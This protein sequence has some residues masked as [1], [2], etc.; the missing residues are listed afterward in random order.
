MAESNRY[1]N[2]TE[3]YLVG[4]YMSEYSKNPPQGADEILDA[5]D[6]SILRSEGLPQL[7]TLNSLIRER[8]KEEQQRGEHSSVPTRVL[9]S[10]AADDCLAD[11]DNA[12]WAGFRDQSPLSEDGGQSHAEKAY[13]E[14]VTAAQKVA[15]ERERAAR[16]NARTA[17]RFG[18][19]F[20]QERSV[21][22][23]EFERRGRRG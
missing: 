14:I 1:L 7:E 15:K 22:A 18:S 10:I 4:E 5:L 19:G 16:A 21:S 9:Q 20:S 17:K 8:A 6:K 12:I 2:E 23:A 11:L 13:Q 3:S